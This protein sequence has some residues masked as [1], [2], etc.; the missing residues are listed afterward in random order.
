MRIMA[1]VMEARCKNVRWAFNFGAWRPTESQLLLASSHL[2][3]EEKERIGRFVYQKDAKASMIG[4]LL[5]RKFVGDYLGCYSS[6]K[7]GRDDKGKPYLIDAALNSS[8]KFN[9]SHQGSYVVLVGEIGKI[10]GVD[11]MKIEYSGGKSLSEFF[12][13]MT[14]NFSAEEWVTIK[15]FYGS[16]ERDKLYMFCRLWSLKESYVKA[17]GTGITVNLQNISFR[18]CTRTL[19]TDKV[20]TDTKLFVNDKEETD[21]HFEEMLL[22]QDHCVAV[23]WKNMASEESVLSHETFKFLT[24][25]DIVHNFEPG[26]SHDEVYC[27]NF[28]QKE[29]KPC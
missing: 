25:Q 24:F 5:M 26:F 4:R 23:A 1:A 11:V 6:V 27:K 15:G 10:V 16:S 9:V 28:L 2:Q 29:E 17:T 12:R 3:P 14:R 22:D 18:I 13:L 20:V 8:L 21:W 19:A 7:F